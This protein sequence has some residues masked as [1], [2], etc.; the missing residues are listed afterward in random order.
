MTTVA[1]CARHLDVVAGPDDHDRTSLPDSGLVYEQLIDTLDVDGLRAV[2]SSDLGFAPIEP[3]V[4]GL[5]EQAAMDLAKV[6]GL[7]LVDKPVELTDPVKVWWNNGILDSWARMEP[8]MWPD[9]EQELEYYNRGTM[10]RSQHV[11]A[12]SVARIYARRGRLER[13]VADWFS[14]V[15]VLLTPSA[16]VPAFAAEGPMPD[17]VNGV[18]VFGGMAVPFTM[19]ANLCWNPAI[20]VPAGVTRDGLPVGLQIV[21][22]RHRDEIVLR[23]ARLYEQARPWPRLAPSLDRKGVGR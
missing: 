7:Q 15:D 22:R 23:L 19:L 11:T 1:D 4:Q 3:E 21:A 2:W 18:E 17:H 12:P 20:S 10:R 14:D 13:E 16:A 5:A 9:R 6:S 8:G